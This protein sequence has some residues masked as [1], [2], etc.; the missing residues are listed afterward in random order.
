MKI[1]EIVEIGRTGQRVAHIEG[2][3]FRLSDEKLLSA[4]ATLEQIAAA[5]VYLKRYA[6]LDEEVGRADLGGPQ[7]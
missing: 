6:A 5:K 7:S 3:H 1:C 2:G 4:G